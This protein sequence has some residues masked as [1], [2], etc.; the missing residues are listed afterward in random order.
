MVWGGII[1]DPETVFDHRTLVVHID[2]YLAVDCYVTRI[3]E[4]VV[5]PLLQDV[6]GVLKREC[7]VAWRALNS[8]T[9]FGIFL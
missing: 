6:H 1:F 3:V 7:V 2:Y 8:L 5:L 4:A 9:R